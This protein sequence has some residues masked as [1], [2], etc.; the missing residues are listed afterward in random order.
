MAKAYETGKEGEYEARLYLEKKGYNILHTNWHYHHFEL[1]IV[2]EKD[3]M[4]VVVEVKTRSSDYLVSPEDSV[5]NRKIR[6][7]VSAADSYVRYFNLAMPVRFD[8]ISLVKNNDG[9]YVVEEHFED[10]FFAPIK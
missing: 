4:L 9:S 6:R 10:A 3:G 1:D 2:A 7:I 5:D 8:I